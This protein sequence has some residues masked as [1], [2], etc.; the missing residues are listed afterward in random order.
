MKWEKDHR[1]DLLELPAAWPP[2]YPKQYGSLE[3]TL[4]PFK[5]VCQYVVLDEHLSPLKDHQCVKAS[6]KRPAIST[7]AIV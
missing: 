5:A 4:C 3:D 1:S 6:D 7:P 2:Q